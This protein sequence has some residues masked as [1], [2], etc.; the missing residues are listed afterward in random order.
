MPSMSVG[1]AVGGGMLLQSSVMAGC[2]DAMLTTWGEGLSGR[3]PQV[4]AKVS[5]QR[6]AMERYIASGPESLG[7]RRR[8]SSRILDEISALRYLRA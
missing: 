5:R 8:R 3:V 2:R 7:F 6:G 1:W 4:D